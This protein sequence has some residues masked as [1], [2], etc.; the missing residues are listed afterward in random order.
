MVYVKG[1]E[2]RA[3]CE[4]CP[5]RA[6]S[7]ARLFEAERC[8]VRLS[9]WTVETESNWYYPESK[10]WRLRPTPDG[11]VSCAREENKKAIG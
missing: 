6:R 8:P 5:G 1:E 4:Q 7:K 11:S 10:S 3:R 2:V 9:V